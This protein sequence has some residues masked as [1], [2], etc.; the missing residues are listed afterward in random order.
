[1]AHKP[2]QVGVVGCG[3]ISG[4][5]FNGM[6]QFPILHVAACADLDLERAKAKGK[7]QGI[8]GCSVKELLADPAIEIVVNLTVP[9]AHAEVN[10][11]AI[12]A[13]KSVHVEKPLALTREDGRRTVEAARKAKVRLGAAP[14]TF[15]GGGIQTCR[16]LI[17]DGAI[18][19]PVAATVNSPTAPSGRV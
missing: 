13:G 19:V 12:R 14:D 17:D 2:V 5:Y 3:N 16:K 15:F 6:K 7:E 11:A 8:R 10:L 1:M 9:K 4:A 18:G